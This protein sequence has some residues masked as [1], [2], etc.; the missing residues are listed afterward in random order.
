MR[1][2]WK[3]SCVFLYDCYRTSAVHSYG[4]T[5]IR[6][7]VKHVYIE[8]SLLRPHKSV[9]FFFFYMKQR[10]FAVGVST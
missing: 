4:V 3:L 7:L 2:N 8:A 6:K 1:N 5:V 9:F 10:L